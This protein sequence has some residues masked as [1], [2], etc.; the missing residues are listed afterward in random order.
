MGLYF[1]MSMVI[2]CFG[3]SYEE[4]KHILTQ[5]TT[6]KSTIDLAA[7][8][9]LWNWLAPLDPRAQ[10]RSHKEISKADFVTFMHMLL[11]LETEDATLE[12]YSEAQLSRTIEF[13]FDQ[14]DRDKSALIGSS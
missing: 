1:L 4:N 10:G 12:M 8:F 3:R 11:E 9:V 5:Q 13:V 2:A 6:N 14:I 7:T